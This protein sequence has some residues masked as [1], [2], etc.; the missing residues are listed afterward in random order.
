MFERNIYDQYGFHCDERWQLGS[1]EGFDAGG[2]SYLVTPYSRQ[3]DSMLIQFEWAK[4]LH[5]AG[6]AE[7]AQPVNTVG[8]GSVAKI[9]GAQ[10]LVFMLPQLDERRAGEFLTEGGQLAHIHDVSHGWVPNV[11]DLNYLGQ[12]LDIWER[13]MGQVES[14]HQQV[15]AR[16][17]KNDFDREFL[18][19][20]P[21][22]LGRAETAMQWLVEEGREPLL[23]SYDGSIN[24][25]RFSNQSWFATNERTTQVKLPLEFVYDHPARD[26]GERLRAEYREGR[27]EDGYSFISEYQNGRTL[28]QGTWSLIGARLLLPLTYIETIENHYMNEGTHAENRS[29]DITNFERELAQEERYLRYT[30]Q[31]L[32]EHLPSTTAGSWFTRRNFA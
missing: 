15:D 12:W 23:Q 16:R 9:D 13:R 14:W 3:E 7:I 10:Q 32:M 28:S 31:C 2:H 19:T 1:Y 26:L 24:H 17:Q 6:V 4:Q 8:G 25:T 5:N 22:Y 18:Y 30:A 29:A 11:P 20:F 27:F 21:Y